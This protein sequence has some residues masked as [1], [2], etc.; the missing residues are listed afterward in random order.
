V[1][2]LVIAR[3]GEGTEAKARRQAVRERHLDEIKPAVADGTVQLGGALLG[4]D[5]EPI[6]SALIVAAESREALETFLKNDVYS[7]AGVWLSFDIFPF[8]RAV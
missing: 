5:G 7:Q 2:F 8:K 1:T 4:D 6:G 3:D